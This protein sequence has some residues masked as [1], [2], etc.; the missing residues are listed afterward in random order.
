MTPNF[1]NENLNHPFTG[2]TLHTPLSKSTERFFSSL[3][4]FPP[5]SRIF[6][7]LSFSP[8]SPW[9]S[10]DSA[11][12]SSAP[13]WPSSHKTHNVSSQKHR[14]QYQRQKQ[15][16]VSAN[17]AASQFLQP[18]TEDSSHFHV[19]SLSQDLLSASCDLVLQATYGDVSSQPYPT[20][21]NHSTTNIIKTPLL[22]MV[23]TICSHEGCKRKQ[24]ET[25]R[26]VLSSA[27]RSQKVFFST[28]FEQCQKSRPVCTTWL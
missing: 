26:W 5:L 10:S 19:C 15:L 16:K 18:L 21:S 6:F 28:V 14:N 1:N 2:T 27:W 4:I 3:S 7:P 22:I 8:L 17:F 20:S 23:N 9:S 13:N 11:T 24:N 12:F 25:W